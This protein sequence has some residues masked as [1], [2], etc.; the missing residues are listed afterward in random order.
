MQ[1]QDIT[2]GGTQFKYGHS[3]NGVDFY[4]QYE[5]YIYT[6]IYMQIAN[7]AMD[8]RMDWGADALEDSFEECGFDYEKEEDIEA[9]KGKFFYPLI[10]AAVREHPKYWVAT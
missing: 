3:D 5:S 7:G 1:R 10:E 6:G 2:I 9:Y 4:Y 8:I